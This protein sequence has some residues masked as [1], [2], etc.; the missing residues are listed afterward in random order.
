MTN[1]TTVKIKRQ[2]LTLHY[3]V[4]NA[5]AKWGH[6]SVPSLHKLMPDKRPLNALYK[7]TRELTA[8]GWLD[9]VV[10]KRK[11][12]IFALTSRAVQELGIQGLE[13]RGRSFL[14][15]DIARTVWAFEQDG[16]FETLGLE[17]QPSI[18]MLDCVVKGPN[19]KALIVDHDLS[20]VSKTFQRIEDFTS[21]ASPDAPLD[22]I[23]LSEHRAAELQRFISQKGFRFQVHLIEVDV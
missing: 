23:A 8:W 6:L 5:I 9:C 22:I 11:N 17:A 14:Q 15:M 20:H 3:N 19:P 4:M 1:E 12:K 21:A 16:F 13:T 7:A 2:L 18:K 10:D